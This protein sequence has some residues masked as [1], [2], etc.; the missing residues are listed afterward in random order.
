[1]STCMSGTCT[2]QVQVCSPPSCV[3]GACVDCATCGYKLDNGGSKNLCPNDSDTLWTNLKACCGAHCGTNCSA[4]EVCGGSTPGTT[5]TN[6]FLCLI[7][8]GCS[9]EYSACKQDKVE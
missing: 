2:I 3:G 5:A 4:H 6:C 8:N 9:V 7:Q 1:V